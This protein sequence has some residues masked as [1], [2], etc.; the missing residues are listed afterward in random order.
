MRNYRHYLEIS[1]FAF[2]FL[3]TVSCMS[4]DD[5]NLSPGNTIADGDTTVDGDA[6]VVDGDSI[7]AVDGDE[8]I[9]GDS[10]ISMTDG[11]APSEGETDVTEDGDAEEILDGDIDVDSFEEDIV[12]AVEEEI[13]PMALCPEEQEPFVMYLSSDDSNSVAS[14]VIARNLVTNGIRPY[15]YMRIWEFLN[16]YHI[17]YDAP[18]KEDM[19]AVYADMEQIDDSGEFTL[20]VAARSYDL[21]NRD[22][23]PM[24]L[25]FVLDTSGSMHGFPID[26]MKET[27]VAI[28]SRLQKGDIV[29]MVTWS[30]SQSVI[31]NGHEVSGANDATFLNAILSLDANGGTDLHAGLVKGYELANANFSPDKL[32][33]VILISD[34]NANAGITDVNIIS[35]NA[36]KN[37][38]D[39]IYLVGVGVGTGYNDTLMNDVTDAGKGAYVFIDSPEEAHLMFGDRFFENMEI[40]V[41]NVQMEVI[42]PWY[43]QMKEFHGEEWS[44]DPR[45][46]EPQ[47]LAPNDAMVFH[48]IIEACWSELVEA[49]DEIKVTA[50][51]ID[52]V[53]KASKSVSKTYS[54]AQ[55]LD[56]NK[57]RLDKG[58]AI[59]R[60][61]ETLQRYSFYGQATNP[62]LDESI[63]MFNSLNEEYNDPD[64]KEMLNTLNNLKRLGY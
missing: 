14:P 9:D 40:A 23:R 19:V 53:T 54:V 2:I 30:T 59:V 61:A 12:E 27:C 36:D 55:L 49:D 38:G 13:D 7:A 60:Y 63:E 25:T 18:S 26:Y 50:N 56:A 1:V 39:G 43:F 64:L 57:A 3:F 8:A 42:L 20:Q 11:D 28:A 33:R 51:F 48:Q 46:V 45:E 5:E 44:S 16:Y 47:H 24:N 4:Y 52:P 31:L 58:N 34:G 32:N 37:E 22:S 21:E 62:L 35:Q 6:S 15:M 29:S 10:D 17:D 41:R